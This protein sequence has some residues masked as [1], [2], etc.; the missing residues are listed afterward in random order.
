MITKADK[1]QTL[2]I[3]TKDAYESK[4]HDFLQ[5]NDFVKI[6]KDPTALY[7]RETRK[8]INTCKTLVPDYSKWK[9]T[10]MN[11]H[12]PNIRGLLKI[13]KPD[14]PIR[15]V[16]NWQHA[17]A[18]KLAKSLSDRLQQELQLPY[19][20]NVK[21]SIHLMSEIS[22]IAPYNSNTR[23]ASFDISNMYTN[24]PTTKIPSIITEICNNLSILKSVGIELIKLI[25]TVLRQNY[26]S[27]Q[28][29]IYKQTT[30]LA[31]GAPTSAILS[32]I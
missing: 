4:V 16:V 7:T 22:N 26:F 21:N 1:G 25:K 13:H 8:T 17:P 11:P 27:F 28:N 20:F 29:N 2:I 15:P 23:L 9:Y 18:Y 12:P 32:E 24:I 30:G 10:N 31:M 19:T 6:S 5:N 14:A 3:I